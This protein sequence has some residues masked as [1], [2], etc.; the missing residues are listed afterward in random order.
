[1]NASRCLPAVFTSL[2]LALAGPAAAAPLDKGRIAADASWAVHFD[3]EGFWASALGRAILKDRKAFQLDETIASTRRKFGLDPVSELKGV[4]VYGVGGSEK[5]AVVV[6]ETASAR[7][8]L[9]RMREEKSHRETSYRGLAIHEIGV[10]RDGKPQRQYVAVKTDPR[11]E[12]VV[13][14]EDR[15]AVVKAVDVLAGRAPSLGRSPALRMLA[16]PPGGFLVFASD[17]KMAEVLRNRSGSKALENAQ[18][19]FVSLVCGD[20]RGTS[21]ATLDLGVRT[22]DQALDIQRMTDGMLAMASLISGQGG[23][24]PN[25]GKGA[26]DLLRLVRAVRVTSKGSTV[27]VRAES[28][29]G[30]LASVLRRAFS[31]GHVRV[32]A[33]GVDLKVGS[34]G[35]KDGKHR[36][37]RDEQ[38]G[39]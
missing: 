16:T 17:R 12:L 31:E 6:V 27:A 33:G 20:D 13:S 38:G 34:S 15:D 10:T 3:G 26:G 21:Y 18:I 29:S 7:G 14:S 4:T 32:N 36:T 39:K 28:P 19:D 23:S 25:D 11:R 1:M 24:A 2:L 9:S 5:G 35:K 30:E 8:I 37:G 22:A